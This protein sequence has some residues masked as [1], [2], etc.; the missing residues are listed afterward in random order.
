MS[1]E[2]MSRKLAAPLPLRNDVCLPSRAVM[3]PM[4][5][6]MNSPRF[7]RAVQA[8]FPAEFWM[9]P[10]LGLS[11]NAVPSPAALRRKYRV[12]LKENIPFFLQY[13][14]HDPEAAAEGVLHAAQAGI[15]GVN[16][17]FACP[18]RTVLKSG[19]GGAILT[20]PFLVEKIL[21]AARRKVPEMCISVKMRIG[22]RDPAECASLLS[23]MK[24]ADVDLVICHARTVE[25]KYAPLPAEEKRKRMS[26]AAQKA[27]KIPFFGNGDIRDEK[28][29]ALYMESGC[30]GI[31]AARGLLQ[32]P[33]LLRRLRGEKSPPP[34]EARKRFLEEF[35]KL[36]S[37][38]QGAGTFAE[39][40]KLACGED[41]P[42]FRTCREAF[43]AK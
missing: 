18:S 1:P 33:W 2:E 28:T 42:Q 36:L 37:G 27:G 22:V 24:N 23:A 11:K 21:L 12:Y 19:S 9:T 3:A 30:D 39:C 41:S 29:A 16:F 4:E 31:A 35:G 34:E 32:D 8:L 40:V 25:E 14:G 17:N 26:F 20:D 5:G 43:G 38:K 13:L 15:R 6:L 10:F 7:F